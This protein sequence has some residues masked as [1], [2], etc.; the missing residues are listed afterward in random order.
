MIISTMIARSSQ[1]AMNSQLVF[2]VVDGTYFLSKIWL[3]GEITGNEIPESKFERRLIA[4][5]RPVRQVFV[6]TST[7]F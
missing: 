7:S 5:N 4:Q 3:K 1:P 2:D 6:G